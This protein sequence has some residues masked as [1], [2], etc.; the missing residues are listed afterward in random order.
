MRG[1]NLEIIEVK[2]WTD[3]EA[4]LGARELR[5]SD[6]SQPILFR[7]QSCCQWPLE[8]T[9]KRAPATANTLGE[10][11][12]ITLSIRPELET[13]TGTHW[14]LPSYE[15]IESLSSDYDALSLKMTFGPFPAY[16]YMAYLRHH[17]FPSPL[18]DWTR[19]PYIA[20]YFAF[21]EV[22]KCNKVSIYALRM[23]NNPSHGSDRPRVIRL[24]PRIRTH[25]RHFAQ[26]SD[27]TLRMLF[28]ESAWRF[29]DYEEE[30][31]R[32]NDGGSHPSRDPEIWKF[33]IP[34]SERA[35]V[36]KLLDQDYNLNAFSLF[37]SDDS[38]IETIAARTFEYKC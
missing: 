8:S 34:A 15:E 20:A 22:P 37:G 24:G 4:A 6:G 2:G 26:K 9:L 27:Y 35:K 7:G 28:Q 23:P 38:L 30:H 29:M 21:R 17:G 18:L 14:S 5:Q 10:Y 31:F 16:E 12:R 11:Y 3:F 13:L 32:N 25:R 1:R 36:L 33:N 19:S